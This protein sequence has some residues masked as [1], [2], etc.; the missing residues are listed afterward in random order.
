[1]EVKNLFAEPEKLGIAHVVVGGGLLALLAHQFEPFGYVL[2]GACA[3][4]SASAAFLFQICGD[5]PIGEFFAD[6]WGIIFISGVLLGP[7]LGCCFRQHLAILLT[8]MSGAT[9]FIFGIIAV[10]Q[11]TE[12]YTTMSKYGFFWF[13]VEVAI[14]YV[15]Y[16]FQDY[17]KKEEDTMIAL[18]SPEEKEEKEKPKSCLDA[19]MEKTKAQES[20]KSTYG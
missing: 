8:V 4:G 19:L 3:G 11:G 9:L 6:N 14:G 20:L 17:N 5:T 16:R 18:M 15:S 13:I 10:F 12:F 2:L 7:T 1:L